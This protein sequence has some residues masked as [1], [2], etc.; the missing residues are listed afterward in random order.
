M[1]RPVKNFDDSNVGIQASY[2]LPVDARKVEYFKLYFD[3]V[4]VGDINTETNRH[5]EQLL[6]CSTACTN[7]LVVGLGLQ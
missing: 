5:A 1:P 7:H 6:A 3:G 4:L 2:K